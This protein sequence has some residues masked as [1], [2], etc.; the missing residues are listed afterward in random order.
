[1]NSRS[2][3]IDLLNAFVSGRLKVIDFEKQ[4]LETFKQDET[5]WSD[6]EYEILQTLFCDVDA[7]CPDPN[8]RDERDLSEEQLF[9]S[10]SAVLD[11]LKSL[12]W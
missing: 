9:N 7:F 10:A 8:I 1:M 2:E 3:Y 11:K 4:Y 6:T 12:S 5:S